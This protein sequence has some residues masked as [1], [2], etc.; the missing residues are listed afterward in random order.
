MTLF[1]QTRDQ[2][3][4]ERRR[5]AE[6]VRQEFAE[7]LVTTEEENRRMAAEV[8]EVRARLRL[9]VERV[10]REKEEELA[11]VHQRCVSTASKSVLTVTLS[12]TF[13]SVLCASVK[14]AILKKEETVNH[15]RKQH[16]VSRP[17]WFCQRDQNGDGWSLNAAPLL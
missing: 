1:V 11:E 12:L 10:T 7:R 17:P 14:S 5:L 16:E 8:A 4:D 13:F 6:V 9:E 2:L 3:V 15:L